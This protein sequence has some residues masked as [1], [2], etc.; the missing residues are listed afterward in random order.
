MWRTVPVPFSQYSVQRH[1]WSKQSKPQTRKVK[2]NRK[3]PIDVR[4]LGAAESA[5]V[6]AGRSILAPSEHH[7]T[8]ETEGVGLQREEK[9]EQ[10]KTFGKKKAATRHVGARGGEK[11]TSHRNAGVS[12]D[13]TRRR[14]RPEGPACRP[15]S[16]IMHASSMFLE[17]SPG[18]ARGRTASVVSPARGL[19]RGFRSPIPYLHF[20]PRNKACN[21]Y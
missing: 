17:G 10:K 2:K 19:P 15:T 5:E 3:N 9:R 11:E 12:R 21:G 16:S 1:D 20:S 14:E 8:S 18:I 6:A 13:R 7:D 4:C